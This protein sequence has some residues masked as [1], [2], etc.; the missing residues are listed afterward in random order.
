M[1]W[2]KAGE[3]LK[4][5]NG[6]T[7]AIDE[8]IGVIADEKEIE[9]LAGIMGGDATA[10]SLETQ[11]IY[12]EA[13]FW[14]PNAIQGRGRRFNFSTD[15]AHRFE[16]GVD[17]ATIVE[18]MERITALI[19]EICGQKDVTKVGPIDDQV[20]N[21]PKREAVSVRTA[22]AVKVIG[23]PLTDEQIADLSLIHI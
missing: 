1:R 2:G 17:F 4:L 23:V 14:Y 22:R 16:R 21:L 5:L 8:W 9:S 7:V 11:D 20:V 3:S 10:V 19:V 18:H 13:A 6:N 12:L 15:A